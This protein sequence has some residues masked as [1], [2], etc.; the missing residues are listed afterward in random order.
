MAMCAFSTSFSNSSAISRIDP[1]YNTPTAL[2]TI[3]VYVKKI[4]NVSYYVA[5]RYLG[6]VSDNVLQ[7]TSPK[8]ISIA[9]SPTFTDVSLNANTKYTFVFVATDV[10]GYSASGTAATPKGGNGDGSIYTL[11]PP[12]TSSLTLT[13]NGGGSSLTTVSFNYSFTIISGNN[14][15]LSITDSNGTLLQTAPVAA[16]GSGTY[17][18]TSTIAGSTTNTNTIYTHNVYVLNAA[19]VGS[20][21]SVCNK[22]INT[23]TWGDISAASFVLP[24]TLNRIYNSSLNASFTNFIG[25]AISCTFTRSGGS[26]GGFT[27]AV[28][29]INNCIDSTLCD[30]N[31]QYT[32]YLTPY[33]LL[34][35]GAETI[36]CKSIINQARPTVTALYGKIYSLWDP[37]SISMNYNGVASS[38]T[39]VSFAYGATPGYTASGIKIYDYAT[40]LVTSS[41]STATIA[42]SATTPN[43]IYRYY[44]VGYNSDLYSSTNIIACAAYV[45]T[46]TWANITYAEFAPLDTANRIY[47]SSL[48][49][50]ITGITGNYNSIT[51]IRDEMFFASTQWQ[52]RNRTYFNNQQTGTSIIDTSTNLLSNTPYQYYLFATNKLGYINTWTSGFATIT[53]KNHYASAALTTTVPTTFGQIY[54]LADFSNITITQNNGGSTTTSILMTAGSTVNSYRLIPYLLGTYYPYGGD[55]KNGTTSFAINSLSP[56]TIYQIGFYTLNDDLIGKDVTACFTTFNACTLANITSTPNF[57]YTDTQKR[58][59]NS[60]TNSTITDITGNYKYYIVTRTGSTQGTYTSTQ[61]TT[62]TFIDPTINLTS[63]TGYTYL[64]YAYNQY[65][66]NLPSTKFNTTYNPLGVSNGVIC[67]LVDPASITIT[68]LSTNQIVSITVTNIGYKYVYNSNANTLI[69]GVAGIPANTYTFTG[70]YNTTYLLT[71][72]IYNSEPYYATLSGTD[73]NIGYPLTITYNVITGAYGNVPIFVKPNTLG[74]IYDSTLNASLTGV[75]YICSYYIITRSGGTQGTVNTGNINV[76]GVPIT[77]GTITNDIFFN[78]TDNTNYT[79]TIFYYNQ[80][81]IKYIN[82]NVGSV[83]KSI[84]SQFTTTYQGVVSF[85]YCTIYTLANPE[86]VSLTFP[87]YCAYN[88]VTKSLTKRFNVAAPSNFKSYYYYTNAN[89]N[90]SNAIPTTINRAGPFAGAISTPSVF[91]VT[92]TTTATPP[93]PSGA[94]VTIMVNNLEDYGNTL[95][96]CAKMFPIID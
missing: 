73:T 13:Y 4:G 11:A 72:K 90:P 91:V 67:T 96:V 29:S 70:T 66:Y 9:T 12:S 36:Q 42:G 92:G 80:S 14:T 93:I 74:S 76:D 51:F 22:T 57:C 10:N 54:T 75:T 61:Q 1:S 71:I 23:C 68:N 28:Q 86:N 3:S 37:S 35:Y 63:N 6:L 87:S 19:G 84:Q 77:N 46:C 60:T 8:A 17:T 56:N 41:T 53:N 94:A 69:G 39:I 81:G 34:N 30:A 20:G 32:Y 62:S 40:N 55:I 83:G 88:T 7:Y 49:A 95:A 26:Q 78:L 21:I 18:S 59:Y 27:S 85:T 16:G 50:S 47:N 65:D 33:N 15:G 48:N 89:N 64:I 2:G 25:S 43:T 44:L 45:D 38:L 5:K 82:Q 31:T 24:D 58:I 79:F 52:S